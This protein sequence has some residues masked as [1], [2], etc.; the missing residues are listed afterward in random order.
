MHTIPTETTF[1]GQSLL[2]HFRVSMMA[3]IRGNRSKWMQQLVV[4]R[5]P[6][7]ALDSSVSLRVIPML[8]VCWR[9][10]KRGAR[11]RIGT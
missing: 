8:L 4:L 9:Y 11:L 6:L 7:A 10:N 3:Y 1:H 5:I 2:H